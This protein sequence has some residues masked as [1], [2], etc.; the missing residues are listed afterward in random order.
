MHLHLPSS[1][2]EPLIRLHSSLNNHASLVLREV[3]IRTMCVMR[4]VSGQSAGQVVTGHCVELVS[5]AV[6]VEE[7]EENH[8]TLHACILCLLP[9]FK[10]TEYVLRV[11]LAA[12]STE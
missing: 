2:L 8:S 5:Y 1:L 9:P 3:E 6:R 12:A 10:T 7:M 4:W 11:R